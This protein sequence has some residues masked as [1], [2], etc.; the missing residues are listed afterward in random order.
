MVTNLYL[1]RQRPL[2]FIVF[3]VGGLL[4][5]IFPWTIIGGGDAILARL[6]ISI[7][8]LVSVAAGLV[9][10]KT[11]RIGL[12]ADRRGIWCSGYFVVK[13]AF[14][15]WDAMVGVRKVTWSSFEGEHEGVLI[16][17]TDQAIHPGGVNSAR[18]CQSELQRLIGNHDFSHPL[19]LYHDEW[20]WRP[21][22]F[23]AFA[24]RYIKDAVARE[25]LRDWRDN[26]TR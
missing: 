26:C 1:V 10:W 21:D 22:E 12:V 9:G 23:V 2:V 25:L 20:D 14:V 3:V 11:A 18:F 17:L 5:C 13:K 15:P 24:S 4:L 8:G 19:L 7:I 6:V 16:G